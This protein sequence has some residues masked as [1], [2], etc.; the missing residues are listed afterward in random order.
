[1]NKEFTL[2]TAHIMERSSHRAREPLHRFMRPAGG[3]KG[4]FYAG[5]EWQYW[6]NK[7]GIDGVTESVAQAQLKWLF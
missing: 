2:P 3:R 7:F 5:V 1:M 6:H 4:Q